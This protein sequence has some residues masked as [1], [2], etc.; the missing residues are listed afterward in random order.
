MSAPALVA[1]ACVVAT[2]RPMSNH[3]PPAWLLLAG[4]VILLGAGRL[5][6]S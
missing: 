1:P 6:A 5:A 3:E 4:A 2:T